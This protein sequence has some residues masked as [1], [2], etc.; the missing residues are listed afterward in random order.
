MPRSSL[1]TALPVLALL[2]LGA[3]DTAPKGP[4]TETGD[5]AT[6][7]L[8]LTGGE[9]QDSYSVRAKAGQ[10]IKVD[11][12]SVDFDPYLILRTPGGQQSEN[13]DATEGDTHRSQVIYQVAES[14]Q[15]SIIAT[16]YESGEKGAYTLVYEVTD[17]EPPAATSTA[18][19]PDSSATDASAPDDAPGVDI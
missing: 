7:D 14:G 13:D 5:L 9:L 17:T 2:A 19:G 1:R 18:A 3:C 15:F 11:L 16:T 12:T 4:V 10:W 8:T 6:G